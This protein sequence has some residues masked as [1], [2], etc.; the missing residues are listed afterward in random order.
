ME[1]DELLEEE[2]LVDELLLEELDELLPVGVPDELV[3]P[4]Q[5]TRRTQP[6]SMPPVILSNLLILN[7]LLQPQVVGYRLI[8]SAI[9]FPAG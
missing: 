6:A 2:L 4:P 7:I 3:P 5:P 9:R 8:I 1:L